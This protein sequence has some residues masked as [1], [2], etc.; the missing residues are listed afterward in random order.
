M[1]IGLGVKRSAKF[2]GSN[3]LAGRRVGNTRGNHNRSARNVLHVKHGT[4]TAPSPPVQ[5]CAVI[6]KTNTAV[7]AL[8]FPK[9]LNLEDFDV[10]IK[11]STNTG[12]N[13]LSSSV[14]A[15]VKQG[16]GT[17]ASMCMRI[18]LSTTDTYTCV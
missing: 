3:P 17:L 7:T 9:S 18:S 10:F 13:G 16:V 14:T 15:V 5:K 6:S 8:F 2:V 4:A 1:S 11:S 12:Q